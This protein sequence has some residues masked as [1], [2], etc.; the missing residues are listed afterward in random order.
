MKLIQPNTFKMQLVTL[1]CILLYSSCSIL[2]E[3]KP[4]VSHI[5]PGDLP[6]L[7]AKYDVYR[8][9]IE[10]KRDHNGSIEPQGCDSLLVNG[11][12][13]GT[14]FYD[15]PPLI[16]KNMEEPGKWQRRAL[17]YGK[18][19]EM[20]QS[21][22]SVSRDQLLGLM[23]YIWFHKRLD[24]AEDL[25]S[26]GS[27]HGWIMGD[28]RY[29]GVDTL[30]NQNL[31]SLLAQIIYNL[32]GDSHGFRHLPITQFEGCQGFRCHLMILQIL[33]DVEVNGNTSTQNVEAV[34]EAAKRSPSN[35]L[36]QYGKHKFTDG[37][38]DESVFLLLSLP[39][40]PADRLPESKDVCVDWSTARTD[41][42]ESLKPC[43][44]Q[45]KQHTGGDFL[46]AAY[47]ILNK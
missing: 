11:I 17:E 6:A 33:L 2:S 44:E 38:Y 47:L 12:M 25:W 15:D 23:W 5:P 10:T 7:Q 27:S 14:V 29:G 28:G 31:L 35:A 41:D 1:A 13:G 16:E 43:P 30:M 8:G 3:K 18:C 4:K 42:E 34:I 22:S 39:R 21:R 36:L 45:G 9:L 20:G 46:F 26:Y 19:Y 24:L 32:G 40:F 37:V